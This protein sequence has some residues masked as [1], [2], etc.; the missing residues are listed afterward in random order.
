MQLCVC[1]WIQE[2]HTHAQSKPRRKP[3][4]QLQGVTIDRS[5]SNARSQGLLS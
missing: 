4:P 3:N 2:K 1:R 5:G